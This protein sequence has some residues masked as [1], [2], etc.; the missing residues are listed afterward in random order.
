MAEMFT[1]LVS[2]TSGERWAKHMFHGTSKI[3]AL[4]GPTQLSTVMRQKLFDAFRILEAN[5][6]ILFGDDTFLSQPG[7]T[8]HRSNKQ[9]LSF[10]GHSL[11][12]PMDTIFELKLRVAAFSKRYVFC[13]FKT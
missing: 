12:D 8:S 5:R 2:E 3:L 4:I 6:A 10:Q 1:Q 9:D 13:P 7:W 11:W